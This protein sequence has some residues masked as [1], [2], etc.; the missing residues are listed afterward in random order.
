MALHVDTKI[1]TPAQNNNRQ[2]LPKQ[3]EGDTIRIQLFAPAG[4]GHSTNG[5]TVELDLPGRTF[6]TYVENVS[7]K[8]WT[9]AALIVAGSA[10]LSALF[11]AGASLPSTGYLGQ[12]EL[13]V[14]KPLEDGAT[15][16][17]KNFSM[18]SGSD[19]DVLDVSNAVVTFTATA[20]GPGDFDGKWERKSGGF[21]DL[22]HSVW[23][24]FV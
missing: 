5:Y 17:V 6:F 20:T 11:V 12:L 24:V 16:I 9:G 22:C 1:E 19:V 3:K 4:A 2:I 23:Q 21:S 7:G 14:R 18:T 10:K 8:D 13:K 15:L